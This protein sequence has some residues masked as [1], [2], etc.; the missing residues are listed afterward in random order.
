MLQVVDFE[1][2]GTTFKLREMSFKQARKHV[3][4]GREMVKLGDAVTSDQW[5]ERTIR[6]VLDAIVPNGEADRWTVE[7]LED[8]LSVK[9][10]NE[11]FMKVLEI[12]GLKLPAGEVTAA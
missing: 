11:L 2:N 3:N 12:S 9:S 8:E 6:T 1:L 5:Y 10:V 4:E 7:K